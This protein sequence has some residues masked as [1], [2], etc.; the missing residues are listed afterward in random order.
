MNKLI[1]VLSILFLFA[2]CKEKTKEITIKSEFIN[3]K[4]DFDF[5]CNPLEN[6]DLMYYEINMKMKE[7][8]PVITC[9]SKN[10]HFRILI[11][12]VTLDNGVWLTLSELSCVGD[13]CIAKEKQREHSMGEPDGELRFQVINKDVIKLIRSNVRQLGYQD[14]DVGIHY[15]KAEDFLDVKRNIF[16]FRFRPILKNCPFEQ[17]QIDTVGDKG[18]SCGEPAPEI[19]ESPADEEPSSNQ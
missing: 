11:Q 5:F 14:N 19:N 13:N 9:E 17:I 12:N 16:L 3:S 15:N 8:L 10:D 6:T 2:N 4:I 18:V 1:L 7:Y